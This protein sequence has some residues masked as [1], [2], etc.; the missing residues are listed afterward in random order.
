MQQPLHSVESVG[1]AVDYNLKVRNA[2]SVSGR[3][4]PAPE[5]LPGLRAP[6]PSPSILGGDALSIPIPIISGRPLC[7]PQPTPSCAQALRRAS[8]PA[9]PTAPQILLLGDSGV[10][11]TCLLT[12][13]AHDS[14][15]DR[16]ASTIGEA[17]PGVTVWLG[18]QRAPT[19]GVARH[20]HVT[21]AQEL[22]PFWLRVATRK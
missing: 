1:G 13:F 5:G 19:P 2:V 7:S 17:A 9:P 16:V 12:R 14:F 20:Q 11:K 18:R 22:S 21:R 8:C 10:G 15:D 3:T 4:G 6:H